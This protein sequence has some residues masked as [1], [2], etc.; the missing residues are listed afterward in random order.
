MRTHLGMPNL[1]MILCRNLTTVFCVI[2]TTI[3]V[4]IHCVNV[5]IATNKNLNPCGAL[6][7][8]LTMPIP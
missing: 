1:Y 5:S 8:M 7:K 3:I 2:F 4:S 6:C